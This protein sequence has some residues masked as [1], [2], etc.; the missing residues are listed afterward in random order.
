MQLEDHPTQGRKGEAVFSWSKLA[1]DYLTLSQSQPETI[2]TYCVYCKGG[3]E[4]KLAETIVQRYPETLAM[5][6]LQDK[7]KSVNSKRSLVQVP[8][9]PGYVFIYKQT[10]LDGRAL[11]ILPDVFKILRSE[12]DMLELRHED[13]DYAL[14]FLKHRGHIQC[15][16]ATRIGDKVRIVEGPLKD[17]DGCIKEISKKNRNARVRIQFMGQAS[18]VWLPFEWVE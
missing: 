10:N 2:L 1:E 11:R 12:E 4:K 9:F 7:H 5:P 14:W 8:M 13:R 18:V 6:I 16:K 3:R 15:S 17:L